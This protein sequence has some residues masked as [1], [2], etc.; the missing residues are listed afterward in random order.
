MQVVLLVQYARLYLLRGGSSS[1]RLVRPSSQEDTT[2]FLCLRGGEYGHLPVAE[3][4]AAVQQA[5]RRDKQREVAVV[6]RSKLIPF[7]PENRRADVRDNS[8]NFEAYYSQLPTKIC[9]RCDTSV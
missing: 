3:L 6:G 9:L 4:R 1:P 2:R 7:K 8:R 5:L